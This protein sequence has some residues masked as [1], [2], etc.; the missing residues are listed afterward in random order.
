MKRPAIV[1][2]AFAFTILFIQC[3]YTQSSEE[4]KPIIDEIKSL[5]EGQD[6]I[7]KELQEIKK[8]FQARAPQRQEF[9]E[10]VINIGND[11]FKGE[12]SAKVTLVDFTD[13]Q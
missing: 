9:K 12:K 11:P 2:M 6:A 4:L 10:A 1:F 5:K 13:Y 7:K 8:L 3:G